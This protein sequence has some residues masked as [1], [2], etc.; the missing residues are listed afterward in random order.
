[1][2]RVFISYSSVD[3]EVAHTFRGLIEALGYEVWMDAESIELS[4]KWRHSIVSGLEG[5]DWLLV[6]VSR[7]SVT[8]DWVKQ[9]TQ[10]AIEHL[11]S[12]VIPILLD[13]TK[14]EG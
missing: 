5:S 12:R 10:W 13:E 11:P 2:P 1:M 3:R 14:P 8:S 6:L 7:H 9:E 4:R